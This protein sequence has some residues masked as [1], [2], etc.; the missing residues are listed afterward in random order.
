[1]STDSWTWDSDYRTA[2]L[3]R[4]TDHGAFRAVIERD[5][6]PR[7]PEF[8]TGDPIID[9]EDGTV[10]YGGETEAGES[11]TVGRVLD[12][13]ELT[14]PNS[15][16]WRGEW[17]TDTFERYV[18]I[19]H[20][21]TVRWINGGSR[22]EE[23]R[24]AALALPEYRRSH[25]VPDEHLNDPADVSEWRAYVEG[26][27]Y[28]IRVEQASFDTE[29]DVESWTELEDTAV[30]GY[31]GEDVAKDEAESALVAEVRE[32]AATMLPLEVSA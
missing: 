11:K 26:D 31:Y 13:F 29:G 22:G 21:G 17:D 8:D 6:D 4:V 25:G 3:E 2:T 1:M 15:Y 7:A 32:T 16:S 23:G 10:V 20:G 14:R 12:A 24:Y 18:R 19:F 28:G 30:W 5:E 9:T 27:V